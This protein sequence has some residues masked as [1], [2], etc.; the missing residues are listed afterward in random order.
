MHLTL[1]F[2]LTAASLVRT[3]LAGAYALTDNHVGA[4]FLNTFVH[5]AIS[6]PTNGR[7]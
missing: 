6:D 5:E 4:D 1:T 7:V 2:V 3:A